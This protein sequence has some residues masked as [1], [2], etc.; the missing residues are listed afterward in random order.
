MSGVCYECGT[1]VTP[2]AQHE[3]RRA[4]EA[5]AAVRLAAQA[6]VGGSSPDGLP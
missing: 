3:F 5:H 1:Q 2:E 6:S 4:L